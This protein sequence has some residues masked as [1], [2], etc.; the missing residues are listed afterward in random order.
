[1]TQRAL[2]VFGAFEEVGFGWPFHVQV[3]PSKVDLDAL[4]PKGILSKACDLLREAGFDGGYAV[5]HSLRSK[6][7]GKA[8]LSPHVHNLAVLKAQRWNGVKIA[9]IYART[10]WV[11]RIETGRRGPVQIS[12]TV[13]YELDHA[14][15]RN[16]HLLSCWWGVLAPNCR[17]K[18]LGE[19]GAK[20]LRLRMRE[21][22]HPACPYCQRE[23]VPCMLNVDYR[24]EI[25]D[26]GALIAPWVVGDGERPEVEL[27]V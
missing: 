10:G 25:P 6:G 27:I 17:K 26:K 1:M 20:A 2:K 15:T 5:V 4:S 18:Y 13:M 14:A 16:G 11:I 24:E 7:A 12:K 3:S 23:L 22:D 21:I 9:Q 8:F 19:A